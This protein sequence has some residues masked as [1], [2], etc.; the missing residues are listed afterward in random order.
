MTCESQAR[1]PTNMVTMSFT[2]NINNLFLINIF[3]GNW[4]ACPWHGR[5][6]SDNQHSIVQCGLVLRYG[7]FF[8]S[9]LF[10]SSW[11]WPLTA[12]AQICNDC[13]NFF[14]ICR[15][16]MDHFSKCN[17]PWDLSK[18]SQLS[19]A[20]ILYTCDRCGKCC[21]PRAS[22]ACLYKMFITR[23]QNVKTHFSLKTLN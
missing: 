8:M 5:A 23:I 6:A 12:R 7:C 19:S 10:R 20:G 11:S 14:W 3:R 22:Q 18:F 9:K 13:L 1:C 17:E 21:W 2:V 16:I 15:N 4:K